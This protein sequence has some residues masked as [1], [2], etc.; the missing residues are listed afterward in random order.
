MACSQ[1]RATCEA[2]YRLGV[3][4]SVEESE[5][6]EI[7]DGDSDNVERGMD[8]GR[9]LA[10]LTAW[11]ASGIPKWPAKWPEHTS[12]RCPGLPHKHVLGAHPSTFP[13]REHGQ[14]VSG[15]LEA[16]HGDVVDGADKG[17]PWG[18][19]SLP[20]PETRAVIARVSLV[21][22]STVPQAHKPAQP[23]HWRAPA[24]RGGKASRVRRGGQR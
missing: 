24:G 11:V 3:G 2:N 19:I 6:S 20:R 21:S 18:F 10:G 7:K 9:A 12:P 5:G 23:W 15:D 4:P 14:L 1:V 13:W 8:V 17:R 16:G 22:V